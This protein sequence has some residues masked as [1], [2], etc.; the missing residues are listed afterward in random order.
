MRIAKVREQSKEGI[1]STS[2]VRLLIQPGDGVRSL[3]KGIAAARHT[4]E[5]M[6]FRLDQTEVER[7][8]ATAVSRG[9]AVYALIAATNSTG[10]ENLR[11]LELRLLAAGVTVARTADDLARY[12]GKLMIIDRRVVYLLAFNLTHADIDRSR[13]FG[14]ITTGRNVVRE[15][16]KLFDADRK[17]VA[18][19]PGL[20]QVVVSPANARTQLTAFIQHAKKDL[21]IYDPRVSDR[22]MMCLLEDRAHAGVNVRLIGRLMQTIPGVTARKLVGLRLHTRTMVRDGEIAFIGSQS[23]R[24]EELDARREVGL[25]FRHQKTV[26]SL[27]HTFDDDWALAERAAQEQDTVG[28]KA[29]IARKVAKAVVKDLPAVAPL[30]NGDSDVEALVKEVVMQ[31]VKQTVEEPAED[32]R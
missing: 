29:K 5:I 9:V 26:L 15:V 25:I 8:L 7:A 11:K 30:L 21:I 6:I 27:I 3:V 28:P 1:G 14:L 18:Y 10:E 32:A 23:L 19:K 22:A 13:S 31:V 17:R 16:T 2:T 20:P 12:H 4:V 24:Q